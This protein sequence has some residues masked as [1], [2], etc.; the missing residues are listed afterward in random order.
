M[1][2]VGRLWEII[3]KEEHEYLC[4]YEDL[5]WLVIDEADRM[6]EAGHFRELDSIL[7]RLATSK[8][9]EEKA[10][11]RQTFV[12][13]ATMTYVPQ[14]K[15]SQSSTSPSGSSAAMKKLMDKIGFMNCNLLLI[16][17]I[18]SANLKS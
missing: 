17:K 16:L 8:P 14:T 11:K 1:Y 4:K 2:C 12:F 9:N 6:I 15:K 10:R 3:E 18:L 13:S 5:R 7:L